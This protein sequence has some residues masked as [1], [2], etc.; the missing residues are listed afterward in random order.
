MQDIKDE[1]F[2]N[3]PFF[4]NFLFNKETGTIRTVIYL[5]KEIVNDIKRKD[6]VFDV[7][8]P[9]IKEFEDTNNVDVRVSGM[10]YI[11]TMNAQNIVDEIGLFV[12][13]ALL[14][15]SLIF[16]FFLPIF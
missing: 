14:V 2:E 11:R 13:L 3:L 9:T 6:F 15:T 10:P 8:N 4:D 16:F 7:L 12:G 1:L 5:K